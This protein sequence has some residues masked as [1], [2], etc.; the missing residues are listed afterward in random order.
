MNLKKASFYIVVLAL[1]VTSPLL[2]H[3]AGKTF[4]VNVTVSGEQ[5][6]Y[7]ARL[8]LGWPAVSADGRYTVYATN[9]PMVAEDTNRL[10]DVYVFDRFTG[11]PRWISSAALG[12]SQPSISAD[13]RYVAYMSNDL[14]SFTQGIFV[15]DRSTAK[16]SMISTDNNTPT[17]PYL[18]ADGRF[19][20]W[21]GWQSRYC[22]GENGGIH[23][24][25][26][27]KNTTICA[28]IAADGD[29]GNNASWNPSLSQ[30]G[31]YL[32]FVSCASNLVS[33]ALDGS[34]GLFLRDFKNHATALLATGMGSCS[35]YSTLQRVAQ[36]SADGRYAIYNQYGNIWVYELSSGHTEQVNINSN[37]RPASL[38]SSFPTIS[39]DGRFAAFQSDDS[40]LVSNDF[41]Q[42]SDVFIHDRFSKKTSRITGVYGIEANS[43]VD[44]P[45]LSANGRYVA[46][47]SAATNL[48]ATDVNADVDFYLRDRWLITTASTDVSVRFVSSPSSAVLDQV[49]T[50]KLE[51]SAISGKAVNTQLQV[52]VPAN[53][54]LNTVSASAG[55]CSKTHYIICRLGDLAANSNATVTIQVSA[56]QTGRVELVAMAGANPKDG[57]SSNN[58]VRSALTVQ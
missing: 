30:D 16:T 3:A 45:S 29:S 21:I 8:E 47:R 9:Y 15:Y 40:Y 51:I 20:V 38:Y 6:P 31:R 11:K 42:S 14:T 23:L 50:Y 7:G 49:L 55:Q 17:R 35:G 19:V 46:M 24:H 26:R 57:N 4:R 54:S 2:T 44:T 18:S 10:L 28:S 36:L 5:I 13:G 37:G 22:N 56:K 58:T 12:G 25:D 32:L 53:L 43:H 34:A 27:L 48:L 52:L 1:L 41:N 39:A 33:Q